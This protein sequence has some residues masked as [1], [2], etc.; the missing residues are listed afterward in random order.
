MGSCL[1]KQGITVVHSKEYDNFETNGKKEDEPKKEEIIKESEKNIPRKKDLIQVEL[2]KKMLEINTIKKEDEEREALKV[3]T[4]QR[5]I[6]TVKNPKEL[7]E[8]KKFSKFPKKKIIEEVIKEKASESDSHILNFNSVNASEISKVNDKDDAPNV[9]NSNSNN[10]NRRKFRR[11]EVKYKTVLDAS[12]L[13][14]KLINLEMSI[15]ILTENLIIQKKGNLKNNYEI[16]RKIGFGPYGVVYK[17][18]NIYLGNRVAIK[19][20]KRQNENEKEETYIKEQI[21]IFKKLTHP[22]LVKIY[23]FH[24]NKSY[25][26]I[27]S[28]YCKKGELLKYINLSFSEKQLAVI[29][30]QIFSGLSYLHEKKVIHKNI[31][32]NNIMIVEKEKDIKTMEEY[33]WIKIADFNSAE[34][35]KIIKSVN[36]TDKLE[37]LY[38]TAPEGLNN[39]YTEKSDTWSVGVIL[40]IALLGKVPFDGKNEEEVIYKIKNIPYNTLNLKLLAHSSEI[41]DLLDKLLQKDL[42]KRLTAKEALEHAWFKKFNGRALFSNYQMEKMQQ[43]INNLCKYSLESKVSQLVIAFLVHNLRDSKNIFS[44]LKI[45]RSF[46]IS[47]NC[48]LTKSELSTGLYSYRNE[49]QVNEIVDKLFLLLDGDNNGYIEFEEFLRACADKKEVLTKENIW[50]AFKFLDDKNENSIDVQTIIRAFDAKPNKMLEA[51]INKTINVGD[52]DNNGK[53]SFSEFE[54]WMNNTMNE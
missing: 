46:N 32:L 11:S 53:I 17:A 41:R 44:I 45:F 38:Y 29:F 12:L 36:K 23:E 4:K 49:K 15:P 13:N 43:Y 31:K 26:Q 47:G 18:K 16:I 10:K 54:E 25:Y 19:L 20:V 48:K 37:N 28:E 9:N 52:L 35:F 24:S 1:C 21:D 22:N 33:F 14:E 3:R 2:L 34:T 27:I 6:N 50:Y 30:Y 40:Y 7:K 39:N 8:I 42:N 51:V 5:V